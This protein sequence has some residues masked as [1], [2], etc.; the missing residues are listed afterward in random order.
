MSSETV[1]PAT[2]HTVGVVVAKL[3]GG[4]ERYIRQ[5]VVG[6]GDGWEADGLRN[7]GDGEALRD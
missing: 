7:L 5:G 6:A 4:A 3:T 1:L 2:E